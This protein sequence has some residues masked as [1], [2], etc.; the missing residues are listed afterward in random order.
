MP[1]QFQVAFPLILGHQVVWQDDR[2]CLS[3]IALATPQILA[4]LLAALV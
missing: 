2:A 4:A 3:L 1:Q